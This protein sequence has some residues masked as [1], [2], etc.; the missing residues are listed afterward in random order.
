MLLGSFAELFVP[1]G[2]HF[3]EISNRQCN[4]IS[5]EIAAAGPTDGP[6]VI[7]LHG[8]PDF[9]QGWRLQIIP[10]VDNG[11]RVLAPNQRGYGRSD[12]PAGV[13]PYDL[14]RLA[15]DVVAIAASEGRTTFALMG[16]DWG[17]IVAWWTAARFPQ[18]VSKLVILNAPHP[19]V[20][21][22]Y[23]L[24]NPAQIVRSW[25]VGLFQIPYLPEWL[26]KADGYRLMWAALC[27][28]APAGLFTNEDKAYLREGWSQPGA[29]TAMIN[30][31]RALFRRSRKS[32]QLMV[33]APTLILFGAQDPTE[34]AGLGAASQELCSHARLILLDGI[35]HW[36]HREAPDLVARE[37]LQFFDNATTPWP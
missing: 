31:Y 33:N 26:L 23:T 4:G 12:K 17:G 3:M 1:F 13:F 34:G 18:N 20:F 29:I 36:P 10:L 37:M 32:L 7:L 27:A 21:G 6:L 22:R 24:R 14:D 30:Y 5:L 15:E 11:Y 35:A 28:T 19:G 8:F 2:L 16:H 9:W 25:Y